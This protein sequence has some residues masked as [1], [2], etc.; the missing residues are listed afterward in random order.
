MKNIIV[1]AVLLLI[2]A[3]AGTPFKWDDARRVQIGMTQAEV[4]GILGKPYSVATQ[5]GNVIYVWSHANAF[6]GHRVLRIDFR[7][8]VVIAAPEIPEDWK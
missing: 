2:V 7:G 6:G 5:N 1:G 4:K 8:G 3:C